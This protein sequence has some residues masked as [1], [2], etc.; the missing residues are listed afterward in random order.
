M[1]SYDFI[2]KLTL[3]TTQA[4]EDFIRSESLITT[5]KLLS[6]ICDALRDLVPV[7]I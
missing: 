7:V 2:I 5:I 4:L 3:N 1:N 6:P